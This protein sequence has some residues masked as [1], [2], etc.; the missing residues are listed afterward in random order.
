MINPLNTGASAAFRM[1]S[2]EQMDY[3]ERKLKYIRGFLKMRP[4]LIKFVN[5]E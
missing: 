4:C 1:Y 5:K 2:I 3:I